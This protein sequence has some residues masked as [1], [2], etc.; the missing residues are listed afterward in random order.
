MKVSVIIPTYNRAR[1]VQEAIGSVLQQPFRDYE[2]I[3]VDDGSTD[4]TEELLR[5]FGARIRYVRQPNQGVNAARN[6]A[7]E[8]AQGEYIA[9]LDNDDLWRRFKLGLEVSI[10]DACPDIGVVFGDFFIL[11]P[12]GRPLPNGLHTWFAGRPVWS[13][14]FD[15]CVQWDMSAIAGGDEIKQGCVTVHTGDIYGTSLYGPR[16]LPSASLFRKSMAARWL[17][18]DEDDPYCG[19]WHFFAR[20]S[21][22]HGAAFIDVETAF[23]RSHE[24]AVRLTRVDGRLQLAKRLEMIDSL[25]KADPAFYGEHQQEVDGEMA[26]CL[27]QLLKRHLFAGDAAA[28]RR[29]AAQLTMLPAP[30]VGSEESLYKMLAFVPGLYRFLPVL[31]SLRRQLGVC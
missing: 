16:V 2:I 8:L 11:K 1:L 7:I 4:G 12:D 10:L 24:D 30:R 23:N 31:R 21:H 19:D 3:V 13:A 25:W 29:A 14:I 5:R 28:A 6:H 18:F 27:N 22:E 9:L 15:D 17:R 26:A 20:L